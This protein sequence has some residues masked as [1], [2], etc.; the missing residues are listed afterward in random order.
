ME[1]LGPEKLQHIRELLSQAEPQSNTN[2]KHPVLKVMVFIAVL[3]SLFLAFWL[4]GFEPV[5]AV[6]V[7]QID[8]LAKSAAA[9]QNR[10][11]ASYKAEIKRMFNIYDFDHIDKNTAATIIKYLKQQQCPV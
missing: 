6:T 7:N 10:S 8:D 1:G 5:S 2:Q 4:N 3:T 11:T 9:C